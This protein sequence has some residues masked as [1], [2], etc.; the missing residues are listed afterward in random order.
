MPH[1]EMNRLLHTWLGLQIIEGHIYITRPNLTHPT[2]LFIWRQLQ[3]ALSLAFSV[4]AKIQGEDI[5]TAS[6][7]GSSQ[8]LPYFAFAIALVEQDDGWSRLRTRVES[9]SERS[10]ILSFE[11][12]IAGRLLRKCIDTEEKQ[13]G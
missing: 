10:A 2:A 7:E 4:T 11:S 5:D 12:H 8:R 13:R 3:I 1:G 6:G 9:G